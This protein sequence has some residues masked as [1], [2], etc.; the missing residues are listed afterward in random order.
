MLQRQRNVVTQIFVVTTS[1][2]CSLSDRQSGPIDRTPVTPGSD[3][4]RN[5]LEK[6]YELPG[7]GGGGADNSIIQMAVMDVSI[8]D[9]N[10]DGLVGDV[11]DLSRFQDENV[12]QAITQGGGCL[13]HHSKWKSAF[14]DSEASDN[15]T[16]K[17][18]ENHAS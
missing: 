10:L 17:K 9:R 4:N 16:E 7:G 12:S 6:F 8:Y 18:G 13:T 14:D 15:E 5:I 3:N 11:I 1:G 2:I